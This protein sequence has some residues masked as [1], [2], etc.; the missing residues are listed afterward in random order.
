MP[1]PK[2]KPATDAAGPD[3]LFQLGGEEA[4]LREQAMLATAA[5]A[6]ASRPDHEAPALSW[7]L[8][9]TQHCIVVPRSYLNHQGF[10]TAMTASAARGWPVFLRDTGG[11]A[12]VQGPGVLNLA[13]TFHVGAGADDRIAS[14]YRIL[15]APVMTMLRRR[16]IE[17]SWRAI[18]GTM[19]DGAYNIVVDGRKLAGTAQRWRGLGRARPG[20]HAVFAHLALFATLDHEM[21]AAALNALYADMG[22]AAGIT[23][24]SHINWAEIETSDAVEPVAALARELDE[25]C[26]MERSD[27]FNID[28]TGMT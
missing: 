21:A 1:H 20:Q 8:W 26:R 25:A 18:A 15:C 13:M 12:V 2:E 27:P 14:S 7:L 5:T 22:L 17:G 11:G 28:A 24:E 16:G 19:C 10:A 23:A 4:L 6:A 3:I 9:Q